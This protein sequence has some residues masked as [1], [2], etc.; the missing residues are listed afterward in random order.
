MLA[1]SQRKAAEQLSA[2][3]L[4]LIFF[5]SLRFH[6]IRWRQNKE[7]HHPTLYKKPDACR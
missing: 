5:F 4:W 7:K 6:F 1:I 2:A 3:F